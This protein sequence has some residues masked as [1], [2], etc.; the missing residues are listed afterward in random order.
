MFKK[1]VFKASLLVVVISAVAL[2]TT[3]AFAA[4]SPRLTANGES[5]QQKDFTLINGHAYVNINVLTD[6]MGALNDWGYEDKEKVGFITHFS[7][8]G[9][10]DESIYWYKNSKKIQMITVK[11][12]VESSKYSTMKNSTI[13]KNSHILL[14]LRDA[15]I[16]LGKTIKWDSKK[17]EITVTGKITY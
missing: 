8:E 9:N 17:K 14:P 6:M 13:S 16:A 15:V 7:E 11:E 1:V 3:T 10:S 12:G 2:L 5:Y 4:D